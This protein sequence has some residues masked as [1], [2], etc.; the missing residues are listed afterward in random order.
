MMKW[1]SVLDFVTIAAVPRGYRLEQLRR[2]DIP[3]LVDCFRT[4][5]PDIATGSESCWH[6]E[7]FYQREVSLEGERETAIIVYVVRSTLE[8]VSMFSLERH[9]DMLALYCRVGAAAPAHRGEKLA[10]IAFKLLEP[11]GR[12]MGMAIVY[13][14]ATLQ[15]RYTQMIAEKYRFQLIGIVPASDRLVV[16]PGVVKHV[17]EAAYVKVLASPADILRPSPENLTPR[18]KALFDH[19]FEK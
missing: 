2:S 11:I 10:H 19:L 4:W 15:H 9:E 6:R 1:P 16:E 18:V 8:L 14:Y 17:Y 3:E 7:D 13:F 12:A 5:F